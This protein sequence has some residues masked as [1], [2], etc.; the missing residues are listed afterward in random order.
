MFFEGA[1]AAELD[2]HAGAKSRASETVEPDPY[3][4]IE[5]VG[6]DLLLVGNIVT[7]IPVQARSQI[8]LYLTPPFAT[9]FPAHFDVTDVFIVQCSGA[10]SWTVF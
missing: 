10:K 2:L 4:K 7:S 9:G 5:D 1:T 3:A 8:N 6:R